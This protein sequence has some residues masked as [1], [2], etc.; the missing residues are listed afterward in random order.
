M[1]TISLTLLLLFF[2]Y[3][4]TDDT[5]FV[6]ELKLIYS[7][8]YNCDLN[9]YLSKLLLLLFQSFGKLFNTQIPLN[10]WAF[11]QNLLG[12]VLLCMCYMWCLYIYI[13]KKIAICVYNFC[14][15]FING[16]CIFCWIYVMQYF[17]FTI[18][19]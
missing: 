6:T 19:V 15:F 9:S 18:N 3:K 10:L 12:W 13:K 17:D 11:L 4:N 14:S 8:L 7:Y 16:K 2:N 5:I 1:R